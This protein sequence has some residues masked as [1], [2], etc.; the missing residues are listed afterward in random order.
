MVMGGKIYVT[1]PCPATPATGPRRCSGGDAKVRVMALTPDAMMRNEQR[2]VW[3]RKWGGKG[4][5]TQP[6]RQRWIS[7]IKR[8][9]QRWSYASSQGTVKTL[10]RRY[11]SSANVRPWNSL[12]TAHEA[13]AK[14]LQTLLYNGIKCA[15][16]TSLIFLPH[17]HVLN[18][19][20]NQRCCKITPMNTIL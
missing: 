12:Q 2:R 8:N 16:I 6:A 15:P 4:I 20:T 11:Q 3:G 7:D 10:S 5:N 19:P 14:T 1:R 17:Q 13:P 9:R 18:R